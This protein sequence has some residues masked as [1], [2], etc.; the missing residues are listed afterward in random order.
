MKQIHLLLSLL[1]L[2]SISI[3]QTT[4]VLDVPY[5]TQPTNNSCQ[6]TCLKMAAMYHNMSGIND[7]SISSIYKE[8]NEGEARPVKQKNAW[9][10]IV[11]WLNLYNDTP[12]FSLLKTKNEAEAIEYIVKCINNNSP[13]IISTNNF[14]TKGHLVLI[15]GYKNYIP[16]QSNPDSRFICHDP[17]GQFF[18][19]LHSDLYGP[20]RYEFGMSLPDG[21][22]DGVGKGVE[23]T[24]TTLKRFRDDKHHTDY[25]VMIG[26]PD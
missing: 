26:K 9:D 24:P 10:N 19:E 23:I 7:K 5:K 21:S 8:I 15:V 20:K 18:P 14:K 2:S 16:N 12:S 22:E 17:Y 3:A 1:F 13:V 4:K 11:W 25:F 6:S